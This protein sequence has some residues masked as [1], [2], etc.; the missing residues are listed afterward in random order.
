MAWAESLNIREMSACHQEVNSVVVRKSKESWLG[1]EEHGMAGKNGLQL[2]KRV[3]NNK[4]L[5]VKNFRDKAERI[6]MGTGTGCENEQNGIISSASPR[7]NSVLAFHLRLL[8]ECMFPA[9]CMR[10]SAECPRKQCVFSL[11]KGSSRCVGGSKTNTRYLTGG[12]RQ[13][14]S[15]ATSV[16][17][18]W[19]RRTSEPIFIQTLRE[20]L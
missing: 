17:E 18:S 1:A 6:L 19:L 11:T 15:S 3:F 4:P 7:T 10:K 13:D 14:L 9:S 5:M 2:R 8:W 12:V 20:G 16:L